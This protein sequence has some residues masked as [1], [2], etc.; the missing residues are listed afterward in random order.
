[1]LTWFYLFC[2]QSNSHICI[3]RYFAGSHSLKMFLPVLA[4]VR[5]WH[6]CVCVSEV[7]MGVYAMIF[8][9]RT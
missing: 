8:N 5:T 6:V 1:M 4:H 2:F 3:G 7:G 9:V